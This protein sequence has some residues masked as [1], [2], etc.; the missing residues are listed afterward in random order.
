VV[1]AVW[2]VAGAADRT[3]VR[4][5]LMAGAAGLLTGLAYLTRPEGLFVAVPLG[6]ALVLAVVARDGRPAA[7]TRL[8]LGDAGQ[9]D[10]G[11]VRRS[12]PG[13]DGSGGGDGGGGIGGDTVPRTADATTVLRLRAAAGVALAF[14]LPLLVCVAPYARFLHEHT[15]TWELTAKT[16]DAS[17]E[18]WHAVARDDRRARD[19][20]LYELD[21]SGFRFAPR[22]SPLPALARE[23]PAGYLGIVATN[24]GSLARNVGGWWLLPLPVWIVA[25]LGAW[26]L[27]RSGTLRLALVVGALP[28]A[29]ALAFFVQPRYLVVTVA[30]ATVPAGA[31]VSTWTTRYRR[32]LVVTGAVLL[33]AASVLAFYGAGGWWHPND[34]T[35]Q[36]RAGEWISAHTD[37]GDRVMTRSLIVGY[38]AD[39]PTLAIPYAELDRILAFGRHYG[40]RYLV[41]DAYTVDE[42][43]P[44]LASLAS[45]DRPAGLELVH[46]VT[47]EGRTTRIFALVPPPAGSATGE[48]APSLGFMG[49]GLG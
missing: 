16:Q 28:V 43:R 17:I 42:L 4:R 39:R 12:R 32:P 14:G 47:A 46:E 31:A 33:A 45:D 24:V 9:V 25:G 36:R 40:A 48:P 34:H 35:D 15:G 26:R 22:S 1:T 41:V 7:D 10:V 23:D 8:R 37:G 30:L 3:G 6:A 49:D 44:Q 21:D 19:A 27:R 11:T 38:Y 5:A 18:A 20:V 13:G 2:L 29:T